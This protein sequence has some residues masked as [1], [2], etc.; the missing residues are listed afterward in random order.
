MALQQI[1]GAGLIIPKMP[2]WVTVPAFATTGLIDATGEK[3]AV[4]GNVWFPA[5]TGTKNISRVQFRWGTIVKAGGSALTISL[6]DVNLSAGPPMQPDETQDQ[7]VAVANADAAFLSNTWYRSGT[8]NANRTVTYGDRL[9]VVV[10]YD[11]SG[12]LGADSVII[13]GITASASTSPFLTAVA[14][15]KTSGSWGIPGNSFP[16]IV[17][18]FDDGTFGTLEGAAV[19]SAIASNAV[20]SGTAVSD[21]YALVINFPFACKVDGLWVSVFCAVGADFEVLLYSGTTALATVAVSA[22]AITATVSQRYC[23]VPI[24]ETTLTANTDYYVAI[25]PT[26]TN[27]VTVYTIDVNSANHWTV[28][29]GGTALQFSTRVDQGSWA[30]KTATRRLHAGVRISSLDDG[31]GGMILSRVRTGF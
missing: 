10:E 1:A 28:Q 27:N 9:S 7:T 17:L 29:D 21:E 15:L 16:L 19:A 2:Q 25:R 22:K 23:F 31:T 26:T 24:P 3:Y 13:T 14:A 8:F 18:E 12:R 4:S 11:G 30:A 20:N 6:Q 5:R